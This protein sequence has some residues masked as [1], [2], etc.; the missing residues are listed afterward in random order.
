MFNT[1]TFGL[2]GVILMSLIISAL[3]TLVTCKMVSTDIIIVSSE[4]KRLLKN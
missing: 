2:C 3:K 1:E 4:C